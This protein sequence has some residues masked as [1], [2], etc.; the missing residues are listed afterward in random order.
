MLTS[1]TSLTPLK[2]ATIPWILLSVWRRLLL[3][4][5]DPQ[6]LS[7]RWSDPLFKRESFVI[8]EGIKD[9]LDFSSTQ[10]ISVSFSD[11]VPWIP[12]SLYACRHSG[13]GQVMQILN[14]KPGLLLSLLS[15]KGGHHYQEQ[16]WT[17]RPCGVKGA[18]K[19]SFELIFPLLR[20]KRWWHRRGWCFTLL[21][22]S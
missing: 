4:L 22:H 1:P 5:L 18:T 3:C 16:T 6:N 13:R 11:A 7:R 20:C 15:I 19:L 2:S 10:I 12:S 14:I 9:V 8:W 17:Q 21:I